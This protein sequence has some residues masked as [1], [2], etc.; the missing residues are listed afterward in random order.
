MPSVLLAYAAGHLAL[1]HSR[2][3]R[4][5]WLLDLDRLAASGTVDW[6]HLTEIA[7][8]WKLGL[9]L[10]EGLRVVERW[11]G[12]PVDAGVMRDLERLAR[13]PVAVRSWGLGDEAPGRAW[14]RA[15]VAMA[16]LPLRGKVR[17]AGWLVMRTALRPVERQMVGASHHQG[18]KERRFTKDE[19]E[20][21]L[22]ETGRPRVAPTGVPPQDVG[23]PQVAPPGADG[24]RAGVWLP[25]LRE[26]LVRE[27]RFVLPLRGN[28]M[29]PTLP[30][31]C[32]IEVRPLPG[33]PRVGELVV[34]VLDDTLVAHRIVRCAGERWI[35]RGDNRLV[36]DR[37]LRGEQMLGRVVAA[38]VAGRRVWPPRGERVL[39]AFWV[40]RHYVLAAVRLIVRRVRR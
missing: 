38:S 9:A 34:F 5:I 12:T 25:L 8:A 40:A 24:G 33:A 4:L 27:G 29:R 7:D 35:A 17:Y 15:R 36:A 37:A 13:E 21:T 19:R 32:E 39:R 3:V 1:H 6:A 30:A 20:G 22:R 31:A 11:L 26:A 2:D 23:R 18:A 16:A 10:H 28:S 14:R